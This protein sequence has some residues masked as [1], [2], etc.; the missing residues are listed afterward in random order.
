M[1]YR[2]RTEV[3]EYPTLIRSWGPV[4]ADRRFSVIDTFRSVG[5]LDQVTQIHVNRLLGKGYRI[6]KTPGSTAEAPSSGRGRLPRP[7]EPEARE[8]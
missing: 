8:G 7:P 6:I 5:D 1:E 4:E 3:N 2:L